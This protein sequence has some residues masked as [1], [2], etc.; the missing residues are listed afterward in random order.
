MLAARA[1]VRS[2]LKEDTN[3]KQVLLKERQDAVK[4]Y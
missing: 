4:L 1:H 3:I 2:E